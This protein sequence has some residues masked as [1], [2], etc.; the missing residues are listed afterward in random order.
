ML[1]RILYYSSVLFQVLENCGWLS[2]LIKDEAASPSRL[3]YFLNMEVQND[4]G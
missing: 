4:F 3:I 1:Q 2:Q